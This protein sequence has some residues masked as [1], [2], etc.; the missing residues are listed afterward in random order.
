[1]HDDVELDLMLS[2][3]SERSVS[4]NLEVRFNNKV[5]QLDAA[6]RKRRLN[7]KKATVCEH[8]DGRISILIA[9]ELFNYSVYEL[10][11]QPNPPENEKTIN[12]RV[13]KAV[14]QR[15]ITKPKADHPWKRLPAT[16]GGYRQQA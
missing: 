1:M 13:E 14:Q 3:Q 16:A 9:G 8:Y 5:Y 10:S 2:F 15:K 7:N 4:K 6:K 11:Q 12:G